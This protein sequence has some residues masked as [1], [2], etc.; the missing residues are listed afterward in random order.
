MLRDDGSYDELLLLVIS[1]A[2]LGLLMLFTMTPVL[3]PYYAV[4]M[5]AAIATAAGIAWLL[6]RGGRLANEPSTI[7]EEDDG[8]QPS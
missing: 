4:L 5:P 6:L 3:R 1:L 8:D 2:G 7:A